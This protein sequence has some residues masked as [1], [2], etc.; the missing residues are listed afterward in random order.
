MLYPKSNCKRSV[1]DLSGFWDF[2]LDSDDVGEKKEW[3]KGFSDGR[4]I[5]VPASWN[6]LY[7]EKE[8]M[9]YMGTAWYQ[10]YFYLPEELSS[11]LIW[12]RIGAANYRAK[13]WIN[14]FYVSEHEGGDL[15]F[16]YNITSRIIFGEKTLL[17]I[18]VDNKLSQD[19]VPQGN[20]TAKEYGDG[21]LGY[22]ETRLQYPNVPYDFYPYGGIHRPVLIYTTSSARIEDIT[23][24]TDIKGNS[25]LV[26]YTVKCSGGKIDKILLKL[27]GTEEV[28]T[29]IEKPSFPLTGE[30]E[31]RDARFWSCQTPFL[32]ELEIRLFYQDS[33]VDEYTLPVG[34]RTIKAEGNKLLLN[35][36]PVF[37]KGFG[38]HEDFYVIGK[39]LL[40]PLIIKDYSLLKWINANS[41]RTSHYPYSEE[42]LNLADKLGF[43][44]ISE[45]S[46]AALSTRAVTSK[47]SERHKEILT[48][49][50]QRDKNH[51]SVIIWSVA[52]EP[53]TSN[54]PEAESYFKELYELVRALD[55]SRPVICAGTSVE[56]VAKNFDIVSI[57]S[58]SGWYNLPGQ[59][60]LA[61]ENFS[62]QLD[63]VY[64]KFKKPIVVTEFGA[65]AITG[66][67]TDPPQ[68]F[69]EEYQERLVTEAYKVAKSKSYTIGFHIWNFAD[70]RTAQ[71]YTR[72]LYNRKGVFT[73]DRQ[74]KILA[75]SLKK[76]WAEREE[77]GRLRQ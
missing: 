48:E 37:L 4:D 77:K 52:N 36:S 19:T 38:K 26:D 66:I 21:Y 28:E 22:Y 53:D 1:I 29:I 3:H 51:P 7:Q 45:S 31:V 6:D 74:P 35:G 61:M 24:K 62:K 69:S 17:V 63:T 65:D 9:S 40:P 54:L 55:P 43:L 56:T 73:R 12:L 49:L 33:L 46:A 23:I 18:K 72:V 10:R 13:V 67:H 8:I 2:K 64:K 76:L 32:Y 70:F 42:M 60:G 34:I 44:V 59:R 39:G 25:G 71:D 20:L 47:T 5:A 50:I 68:L 75:Y 58:Y 41:Y 11:K 27:N 14:G 57:H 30:L 16:E 15:P